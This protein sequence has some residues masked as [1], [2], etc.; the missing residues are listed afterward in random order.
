MR[1]PITMLNGFG[2][3]ECEQRQNQLAIQWKGQRT[4][5][6]GLGTV[7][8]QDV[9][10]FFVGDKKWTKNTKPTNVYEAPGSSVMR[11]IPANDS[12]KIVGINENLKWGKLS[13]G[14][15]VWLEDS[16]YTV[17]LDVEPPTST[18]DAIL[19]E[20]ERAYE[21]IPFLPS[22]EALK[23]ALWVAAGIGVLILVSKAKDVGVLPDKKLA[24]N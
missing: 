3:A 19:R 1:M 12:F 8:R 10:N 11:T 16:M 5:T 6:Y 7:S 20:A 9:V 15:W 4:N 21:S 24:A 18:G 17:Y 14:E 22:L 13:T 2:C 23:V